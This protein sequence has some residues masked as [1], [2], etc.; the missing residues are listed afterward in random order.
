MQ[1]LVSVIIPNYNHARFLKRRI[2]TV[3]QQTYTNIEVILLDDGSTDNSVQIIRDFLGYDNRF[4]F[5]KNNKNSGSP[6]VQWNKGVELANGEFIWIAESDDMA[7]PAFLETMVKELENNKAAAI[8]YCESFKMDENDCVTGSWKEWTDNLDKK[9]FNEN[10]LMNGL[11]YIEQFLI[12]Q[13]TIPNASA[14]VFRKSIFKEIGGADENIPTSSDW[15]T[16]LKILLRYDVAF[17]AQPL[18]FF[19][20]HQGS[21]IAKAHAI[22]PEGYGMEFDYDMRKIVSTILISFNEP[23]VSKIG[24]INDHYIFHALGN[25]GL[26]IFKKGK[27][28]RGFKYILCASIRPVITFNFIKRLL[29][30]KSIES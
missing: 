18:N 12:Y 9:A 5:I 7:S 26:Y 2:E 30:T 27:K 14:V 28:I 16:W 20:Y 25:Y 24:K 17:V 10:F 23:F 19:R 15:L 4:I 13:N 11:E 29:F 8:A 1:Q 3:L 21:V 22:R 6:F